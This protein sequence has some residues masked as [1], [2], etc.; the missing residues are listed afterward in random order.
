M[1]IC[2]ERPSP[3]PVMVIMCMSALLGEDGNTR[4]SFTIENDHDTFRSQMLRCRVIGRMQES[5]VKIE[6]E[7]K[8]FLFKL[9]I[10]R[11]L[12]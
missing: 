6:D 5:A 2:A 9:L 4:C 8:L 11:R 12:V 3:M 10:Q 7:R 1:K